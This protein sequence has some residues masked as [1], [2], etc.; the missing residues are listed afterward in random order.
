MRP[1][2]PSQRRRPQGRIAVA[3]AEG[4]AHV[5]W[6]AGRARAPDIARQCLI[7]LQRHAV[8]VCGALVDG[9]VRHS[10]QRAVCSPELKR[11]SREFKSELR[12]EGHFSARLS[13]GGRRAD[14]SRES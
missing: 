4:I 7:A 2:Q 9:D 13:L 6:Q 3:G 1:Q 12:L 14:Q 5:Q 8:P 10:R 11:H